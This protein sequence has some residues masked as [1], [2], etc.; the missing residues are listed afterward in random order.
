MKGFP[1]AQ[2][3]GNPQPKTEP[4]GRDNSLPMLKAD[5][6]LSLVLNKVDSIAFE[7]KPRKELKE[8]EVEVNIRQTGMYLRKW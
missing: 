3:P 2:A 4:I 7:Q 1:A 6:N 8:G 5:G